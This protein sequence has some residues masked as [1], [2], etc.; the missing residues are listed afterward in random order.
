MC[1][2]Q[3]L[4]VVELAGNCVSADHMMTRRMHHKGLN[5]RRVNILNITTGLGDVAC[6]VTEENRERKIAQWHF[7]H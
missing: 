6:T 2:E 5:T 7:W 1:G 3:Q 4:R